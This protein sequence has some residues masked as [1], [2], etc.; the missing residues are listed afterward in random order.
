MKSGRVPLAL[1]ELEKAQENLRLAQ[2][3]LEVSF[4]ADLV[5]LCNDYGLLIQAGGSEGSRLEVTKLIGKATKEC[6]K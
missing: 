2:D 1:E 5:D 6:F 3:E 4:L